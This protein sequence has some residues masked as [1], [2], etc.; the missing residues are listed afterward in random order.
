MVPDTV[1]LE[2]T[3][4]DP[5]PVRARD[6][7]QAYAEELSDLVAMLETPDGQTDALIRAEIVD[8]AS[9]PD[10]RCPRV[11]CATSGWRSCSVCCSGSG[12]RWCASCWTT[13]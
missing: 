12:S 8:N 2:I 4:T 11:R 6:I 1:N 7:A 9:V 3:A 13:R 5:D 10:V